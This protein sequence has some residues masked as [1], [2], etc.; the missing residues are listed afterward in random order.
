MGLPMARNVLAA[1]FPLTVFNRT[2]ERCEPLAAAGATVATTPR[3]LAAASDLVVTMVA[4]ADAV[5]ALLE[6][7]DGIL[8]GAV[9]GLVLAEMST[10]GPLAVRELAA[11]CGEQ[12]VEMLDA[13][14]SGSTAVAEAAQLAVMVG[15]EAAAFERARPV[16][17][18]IS[19]AQFHLGPSGAGA[20]VKVGLNVII[21]ATTVAVSEALVLAEEAGVDR[22]AA[23][24][25]I[26]SSAVASPFVEYKR[27]AFLDPDGTPTA[28]ALE[29]MAKDLG[30]A[31]ALGERDGVPLLGAAASAQMIALAAG[32]EGPGEDLVRVA[33][34][35]RRVGAGAKPG[36]GEKE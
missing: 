17:A 16:L 32:L 20:A 14:V 1:G 7:P 27:A 33:D 12:G 18:A 31:R 2:P 4:D 35:L 30:L 19:K 29:L 11:L 10:I 23:Y 26:G 34:A 36:I 13:P 15:G 21:A 8:A 25:V 9:P 28:F 24:E 3:E 22:E 5:R 6:G